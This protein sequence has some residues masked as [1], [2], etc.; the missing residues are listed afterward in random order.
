MPHGNVE[1][2]VRACL[3]RSMLKRVGVI[4]AA[5]VFVS[6]APATAK[7]KQAEAPPVVEE[8]VAEEPVAEPGAE[9]AAMP[10]I[11]HLEGP[12]LVDLGHDIEIDLPEGF[13]LFE[14]AQAQ[15]MVRRG[16]NDGDDVLAA[17]G[18]K[19]SEWA[20]IIEYSDIG[21]VS[22]DDA[23]ELNAGELLESY[24]QGTAQQNIKRKEL[25]L[26]E[27]FIDGWSEMPRY[28]RGK[29]HLVWGINGHDTDGKLVNHF[30]R[31]LGRGGFISVNLI[32]APE[33]L[34]QARTDAQ[35]VLGAT[36]YKLGATYADYREG[37]KSSGL[38]LTALVLGG[39]G[40]AKVAKAGILVAILAFL[41]KGFVLV[42]LPFAALA[43]WLFGRKKA[44]EPSPED[45][46]ANTT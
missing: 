34:E 30:T 24:R 44:A 31:I 36:R 26:P 38:G 6:G 17:V 40:V 2:R 5:V 21:Y 46:D 28:D 33:L 45:P 14:R 8:P 25:G 37:D 7:G 3:Y 39:A 15:E 11:P 4:I 12:K 10:D 29:H 9:A 27:L 23:D 1:A 16:G 42:L 41:K 35:P 19:D 20:I 22:D 13:V 43:R 18:K 32:S